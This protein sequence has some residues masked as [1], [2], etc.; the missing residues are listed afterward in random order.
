LVLPND[1]QVFADAELAQNLSDQKSY[2][3]IV[4]MLNAVIIEFKMKKTTTIMTHTTDS[5]TKAQFAAVCRLQP[6]RRLLESMGYPC[7]APTNVYTDNA[8]VSAIVDANRMTPCC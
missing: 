5:E 2:Y 8:A 6:I 3:C 1:L 7:P 4:I